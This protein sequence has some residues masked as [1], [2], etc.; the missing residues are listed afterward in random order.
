MRGFFMSIHLFSIVLMI[1]LMGIYVPTFWMVSVYILFVGSAL[2][3]EVYKL[4]VVKST[5]PATK[6]IEPKITK[7][8]K[9]NNDGLVVLSKTERAI[10]RILKK[11]K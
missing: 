5:K 1:V 6:P 3:C 8:I 10:R 7:P 4:T 11:K 9:K 2:M